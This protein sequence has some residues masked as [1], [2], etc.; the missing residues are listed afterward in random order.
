MSPPSG[1]LLDPRA[2]AALHDLSLVARTVVDGFMYGVHRSRMPGAGLEFNQYR[3]YQPGDDI[4]RVDWKLFGRSD[5]YFIRDSET[6]TSV[7]VR[8]L[9]DAS[10]SMAHEEDGLTRLAYARMLAAALA[11]LASRQ[12]DAV[13][14]Y[15][16][17][18]GRADALPPRRSPQHLHQIFHALER[19]EPGGVWPGWERIERLLAGG[20]RGIVVLISDLHERGA[21]IRTVAHKLA[22]LRH[23]LLV[24]HLLGRHETRFDYRGTVAFEELETGRRVRVNAAESRAAYLAAMDAEAVALRREFDDRRIEYH[25]GT[26]DQPLDEALRR[27]LAARG[28][29]A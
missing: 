3:S 27:F 29:L 11:L 6:E 2:L 20:D 23:D 21:E 15:L 7:T 5:R 13:G 24:L 22:A 19:L 9:L 25:R 4:R 1:R 17:G 10:G 18:H 28:P 26:T 8:I 16:L 12:G 14:L